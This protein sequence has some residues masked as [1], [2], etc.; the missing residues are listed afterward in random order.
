MS[1]RVAPNVFRVAPTV[2]GSQEQFIISLTVRYD[3][4]ANA[5]QRKSLKSSTEKR[6]WAKPF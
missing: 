6:C 4:S 5:T 3:L 2:F 1:F